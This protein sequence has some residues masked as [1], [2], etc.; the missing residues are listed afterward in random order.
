MS[1][2]AKDLRT[3]ADYIRGCL[4]Y[5]HLGYADAK[6]LEKIENAAAELTTQTGTLSTLEEQT[7]AQSDRIQALTEANAILEAVQ[8]RQQ[9]ALEH[10]VEELSTTLAH[11]E[12][13]EGHVYGKS[14]YKMF[15]ILDLGR[16]ALK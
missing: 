16:K 7:K 4:K 11:Y 5:G 12:R 1:Y 13:D 14:C 9:D 8:K 3:Q 10:I 2:L 15:E 6:M